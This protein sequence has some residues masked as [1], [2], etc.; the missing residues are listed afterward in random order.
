MIRWVLKLAEFNIEGGHRSGTQNAVANV[1]S[2]NTV[3][4]IAGELVNCAIIRDLVLSSREQLIKEERKDPDVG[5]IYI[6]IWKTQKI[7]RLM[8]QYVR[9][10]LAI[11]R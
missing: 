1:I 7:A 8:R 3:Q 9:T 5:H 6:D 2:R 10:G 11:Y 4:S